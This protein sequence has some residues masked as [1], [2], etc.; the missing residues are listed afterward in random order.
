VSPCDESTTGN[1]WPIELAPLTFPRQHHYCI[2]HRYRFHID[3]VVT[4]MTRSPE[5][6]KILV[7]L[8]TDVKRWLESECSRNLTS[9]SSQLTL[10]LR[11]RMDVQKVGAN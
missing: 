5:V 8:P 3:D 2:H 1:L 4:T 7:R 6:Q 11:D 9:F 10:I